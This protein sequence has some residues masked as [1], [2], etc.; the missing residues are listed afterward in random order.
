MRRIVLLLM[1]LLPL[2]GALRAQVDTAV[3]PAATADSGAMEYEEIVYQAPNVN[4][5][6]LFGSPFCE[7]FAEL[8][9]LL[10]IEDQGI[11]LTYAYL[12]EVWGG[13]A[14]AYMGYETLW[15]MGGADYRMSK[16]W[17][18]CDVHLCGS[19]G[20]CCMDRSFGQM[21]PAA[22]LGLRVSEPADRGRLSLVSGNVGV[23]TDFNTY[24][25]TLGFSLS[26]AALA[27]AFLLLIV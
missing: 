12:P 15:L 3:Q 6:Y 4:P 10:G 23:V 11:G 25:L 1:L 8:G 27:S 22:G 7:H 9:F 16:P 2:A 19:A 20:V 14:T 17:S 13:H 24:Y 26:L 18:K 5:I 21:R